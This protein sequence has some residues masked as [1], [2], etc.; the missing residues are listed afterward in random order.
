MK[1]F[2]LKRLLLMLT[3]IV[4]MGVTM[5]FLIGVN[6]GTDTYS[7]MALGVSDTS[8]FSYGTSCLLI[9]VAMFIPVVI[10]ERRLIHIG[11][12]MNMVVVGYITD[13]CLMLNGR[14]L[15]DWLFTTLPAKP[16]V[17]VAALIP[18]LVAVAFYMNADLGMS[19]YDALPTLIS[20][21]LKIPFTPVRIGWDMLTIAV[22]LILGQK[23][24]L[25]TLVLALTIGPA[26]DLV[27]KPLKRFFA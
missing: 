20:R 18:F 5:S 8:G 22:G 15:P 27:G 26:V 9:N 24:P 1:N 23:L 16:I 2:S 14:F 7:F 12:I 17:F 13:F 21:R 6:Y 4:F 25:G 11:T 19:P 3:G 10:F